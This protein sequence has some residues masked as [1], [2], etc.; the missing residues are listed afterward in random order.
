[1][2]YETSERSVVKYQFLGAF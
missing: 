2:Q 1:M